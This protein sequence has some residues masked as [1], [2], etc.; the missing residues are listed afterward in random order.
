MNNLDGNIALLFDRT[1]ADFI[2]WLS[3]QSDDVLPED[4]EEVFAGYMYRDVVALHRDYDASNDTIGAYVKTLNEYIEYQ[5]CYIHY[6]QEFAKIKQLDEPRR[7]LL[8]FDLMDKLQ[9]ELKISPL[10]WDAANPDIIDLYNA[11]SAAR[12]L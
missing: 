10:N 4:V 2:R 11:I 3:E 5:L 6:R 12:N 8:L 7:T 9:G 1:K